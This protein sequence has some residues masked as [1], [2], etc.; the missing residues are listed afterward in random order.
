MAWLNQ[1][2]TD[3]VVELRVSNEIY[4]VTDTGIA[5]TV[6]P[7]ITFRADGARNRRERT[8]VGRAME[9]RLVPPGSLL[10]LAICRIV[11]VGTQLFL[12]FPT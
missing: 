9:R 5:K 1:G 2:R 6:E 8:L 11:A 12:S 4:A 7:E 3:S 10:H